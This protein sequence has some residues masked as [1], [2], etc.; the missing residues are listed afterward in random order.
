VSDKIQLNPNQL[1]LRDLRRAKAGP[2]EGRDPIELIGA[3]DMLEIAQLIAWCVRSRDDPEFAW[4]DAGEMALG[5]FA[6]S[7]GDQ[8]PPIAS[9]DEP[10][11]SD[12]P[13]TPRPSRT[14]PPKP[15]PPPSSEPSS[16]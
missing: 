10:G 9:P 15:G 8:P 12:A 4:S 7:D 2:L 11:T 13:P 6:F 3:G 1:T 16:A 5:D 14:R